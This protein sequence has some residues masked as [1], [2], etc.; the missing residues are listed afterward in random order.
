[1]PPEKGVSP[2]RILIVDDHPILREGVTSILEDRTDMDLRFYDDSSAE[3]FSNFTR[4]FL[5]KSDFAARYPNSVPSE[6]CLGLVLM[7]FHLM[8]FLR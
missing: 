3:P 2:I 8:K 7:N 4:L 1:M 5:S 6:N